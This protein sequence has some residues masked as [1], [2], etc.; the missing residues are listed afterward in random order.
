VASYI[1]QL[2]PQK[3]LERKLHEAVRLARERL[4]TKEP[5]TTGRAADHPRVR[6]TT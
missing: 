6:S 5:K 2:L 1:D 4:A 3:Q